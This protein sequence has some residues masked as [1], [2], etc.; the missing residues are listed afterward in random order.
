MKRE[1]CKRVCSCVLTLALVLTL[2]PVQTFASL[3]NSEEATSEVTTADMLERAL[4]AGLEE[5]VITGDFAL[6]RTFYVTANTRMLAQEAHTLSRAADFDGDLFVIG[7]SATGEKTQTPVTLELGETDG[8]EL[9]LDGNKGNLEDALD[10]GGSALYVTNGS[11]VTVQNSVT[12]ANHRKDSNVRAIADGLGSAENTGGAVILAASGSVT[13]NGA[14]FENNEAVGE[15]GA[16]YFAADSTGSITGAGFVGN[17]ATGGN[18]S[19]GAIGLRSAAV[20]L[21]NVSFTSN[22]AEKNGGALFV[23]YTSASGHNADVIADGCVFQTNTSANHGGAVYVTSYTLDE[24]NRIFFSSET[25]YENNTAAGNGGAVYVTGSNVFLTDAEFTGNTAQSASYGGGAVYSTGGL[26]EIDKASFTNN[27]AKN[28]GAIALYSAST[29]ILNE[30]TSTGNT[31]TGNGGVLYNSGSE[32]ALYDS[33]LQENSAASNGG[34]IS[35][36][37]QAVSGIYNTTI[38][39]NSAGGN[40]GALYDYTGEATTTVH[41]CTFAGNDAS[42]GNGGALFVSS[43]NTALN[44]YETTITGNTAKNGG[45]L[46]ETTT[47]ATVTLNGLTVSGNT[48]EAGPIIYGNT[49]KAL[50]NLNKTNYT[51]SDAVGELDDAYWA[52]AIANKLT[53]NEITDAVPGYYNYQGNYIAVD[54]ELEGVVDVR[55][56]DELEAAIDA[57]AEQIRVAADFALDRTFYVTGAT[58]IFSTTSHTIVRDPSFGGDIFVIGESADAVSAVSQGNRAIL[59][60]GDPD[61]E[62]ANLLTIDGNKDGMTV[63]V[64]GTVLFICFGAAANLYESV[65]IVN[66]CK[67]SNIRTT[68]ERYGLPYTNRIGGAVAIVANGAL[69]IFG[70]KFDGNIVNDE[71]TTESS[72][73]SGRDSTLGAVIF[74]YSNL[75]IYGGVFSNN[76]AA[77]GGAV[78]NYRMT[79]VYGGVFR[80]NTATRIAGAIYQADSQYGELLIGVNCDSTGKTVLFEGNTS[81]SVGGAIFSQTKNALIIYGNTTFRGN[82]SQGSNGGAICCYGTLTIRNA[83]FENNTA[84]LDSACDESYAPGHSIRDYLDFHFCYWTSYGD[85]AATDMMHTKVCAVSHY[86]DMNG[87]DHANAVWSSSTNLDGVTDKGYNGNNKVQTGT[88]VSD[89]AALYQTAHNYLQLLGQYCGQ[90]DVYLFREL[91]LQRSDEQI[92]L[93]LEGRG[94]EIP[95]SE[96]IVYLGTENDSVFE[97]YFAPIGVD[98]GVWDSVSNPYCK[99]IDKLANSDDYIYFAWN[100]ANFNY[101]PL[102]RML[103]DRVSQA[104]HVNKNSENRLFILLKGSN[105]EE[106]NV[107]YSDLTIGEDIGFV[108]LNNKLYSDIHHKDI[109][110][111][112]S[113]NGQRSYVSLLNSLNIHTGS[114]SYQSNFILVIKESACTKDSVFYTFSTQTAAGM[115]QHSFGELLTQEATENA[116]GY[117]YRQCTECGEISVEKTIHVPSDMWV[118]DKAATPSQ[119][120]IRHHSCRICGELIDV[121]E[122]ALEE[123]A[124]HIDSEARNGT[125]FADGSYIQVEP[126]SAGVH[127]FETTIQIPRSVSSRG[128]VI[129]G[130]YGNA[131]DLINVEVYTS[132]RFRLYVK[133]DQVAHTYLFDTDVRS[134]EPVSVIMTVDGTMARLYLDGILKETKDL[135]IELPKVREGYLIGADNR[136]VGVPYFEGTVFDVSLFSDVRTSEEIAVDRVFVPNDTDGLIYQK[137]FDQVNYAHA[138]VIWNV[139]IFNTDV[140][141]TETVSLALVIDGLSAKLHLNGELADTRQLDTAVPASTSNYC[142]GGDNRPNNTQ[143]FRGTLLDVTMF[144]CVRSAAEINTDMSGVSDFENGLLYRYSPS[145]HTISEIID[146]PATSEH[147]GVSHFECVSCGKVLEIRE[148]PKLTAEPVGYSLDAM[149]GRTFS[150]QMESLAAIP[151]L[152]A[153]PYTLEAMINVPTSMSDRAGVVISNYYGSEADEISLEIYSQGRPRLFYVANGQKH[154][155]V[156]K[157]DIRSD[158][159]VHIAVTIGADEAKLYVNGILKETASLVAVPVGTVKDY[160]LGGDKRSGNSQYFKGTIFA[161]ALFSDVRS[162]E[163]IALDALIVT[164]GAQGL[165]FRTYYP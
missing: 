151:A 69:N 43:G 122:Y 36:H 6:D 77:R 142:V 2:L 103:L 156:F 137:R 24:T 49:T 115:H 26:V 112:Y 98:S 138:G 21:E 141:S 124:I 150:A 87:I 20:S 109:L 100:N 72:D 5:I 139:D 83:A 135:G 15:G 158:E 159:P 127:T 86:T 152:D 132:G 29:A 63:E 27:G 146:L 44:V 14:R 165:L 23:S 39:S 79:K 47:G 153:T 46:Y 81:V 116:H 104:F 17:T 10:V 123:S 76:Q 34:A 4:N 157:S 16:L 88:I 66:H 133:K 11:S 129:I 56:A 58:T 84:Y 82:R 78:Y 140:R 52:A 134:D 45:V 12:F 131:G 130:N 30:L 25:V 114:M 154:D 97:L 37:S 119:M 92:R 31:A 117:I 32:L 42:N 61:S 143:K 51:D 74:N 145:R 108:S 75:N 64:S 8:A 147:K 94:G 149:T 121:A 93:I 162:A 126:L 62:I 3:N 111:S 54:T 40:G 118:V 80:N 41:S 68:E 70:G 99:F 90:E 57:G 28:G 148:L 65:S 107:Q 59:N 96:R 13:V 155:I 7:E 38:E 73:E 95:E 35:L 106:L 144:D 105:T 128:G 48:A 120:G 164:S 160:Y 102:S 55:S 89:H 110:L 22:E 19:G 101:Y 161:A 125:S 1:V 113:E 50:L 71:D 53:V 91:A 85:D 67:T 163:E 9:T 33:V 136:S 18:G 60:L